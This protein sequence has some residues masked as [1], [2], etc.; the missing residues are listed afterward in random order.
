M[1]QSI[2]RGS[3]LVYLLI[4]LEI[5]IMISPFAAYFY[6]LYSP[7]LNLMY[8]NRFT[9]WLAEF[10]LPHFVFF[11]NLFMKVIGVVQITAF[12][13]GIFLFLYAAIPLYYY[14][15]TKRGVVTGGIYKKVRH[16]QYLGFGM[17]GFGLLLYWPRFF[18]LIIYLTMLFVYYLLARNEEQRMISRYPESYRA[19]M[20]KVPMFMPGGIGGKAFR[21]VFGGAASNGQALAVFYCITIIVCSGTAVLLRQYSVNSMKLEEINGLSV[22]SVLPERDVSVRKVVEGLIS[23][24][25]VKTRIEKEGVTLAYFMPSDYFLMALVT[26]LERLYP[27][28]F[29]KSSEEG[30]VKRFFKIFINYTK[31]QVGIYPEPHPLKRIIFVS[32]RDENGRLL[33][34]R[35]V[36]R[37]GAR[38]YPAFHVDMDAASGRIFSIQDLKPRNKWGDIPMPVF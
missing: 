25:K 11:D 8:S 18:I 31:M 3:F 28:D 37:L 10:F 4:G 2:L 21:Y 6:F 34:G 12:F 1:K 14:K 5:I 19:Y 33:K 29:E 38:R 17:A 16:P 32:V 20:A 24:G 13:T 23:E 15:I 36:F 30:T 22:I 9:G 26:D 35:D 7:F 27:P